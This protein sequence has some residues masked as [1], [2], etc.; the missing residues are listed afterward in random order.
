[1]IEDFGS[2]G[3]RA[4]GPTLNS[5]RADSWLLA[6]HRGSRGYCGTLCGNSTSIWSRSLEGASQ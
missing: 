3:Q 5:H 6:C 2:N 1:M 4:I